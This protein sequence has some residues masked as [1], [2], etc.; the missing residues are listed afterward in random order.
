MLDDNL[1]VI[2]ELHELIGQPLFSLLHLVLEDEDVELLDVIH[3][4]LE[5]VPGNEL[6]S[7]LFLSLVDFI[8]GDLEVVDCLHETILHLVVFEVVSEDVE[9]PTEE[10][11]SNV[12]AAGSHLDHLLWG[13]WLFGV[14]EAFVQVLHCQED[15]AV[16][17]N[18][19]VDLWIQAELV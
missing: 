1:G 4:H 19:L 6:L 7:Y 17:L 13:E 10:L 14:G 9:V 2:D 3:S 5:N 15:G 8:L 12:V 16:K 18:L 11:L